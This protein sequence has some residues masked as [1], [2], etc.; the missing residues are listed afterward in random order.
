MNISDLQLKKINIYGKENIFLGTAQDGKKYFVKFYPEGREV[1]MK[2]EIAC[3]KELRISNMFKC[4]GGDFK[5]KYIILEY[6]SRL[7]DLKPAKKDIDELFDIIFNVFASIDPS[8]LPEVKYSKIANVVNIVMRRIE[9][10]QKKQIIGEQGNMLE[11]FE[12]AREII[13]NGNV[14]VHADFIFQNLKR[15]KGNI[16]IIDFEYARLGHCLMDAAALYMDLSLNPRVQKYFY[17]KLQKHSSFDEEL[18]RVLVWR[19]A[20]DQVY[21]LQNLKK[22]RSYQTSLKTLKNFKF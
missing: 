5:E 2:R 17:S 12:T 11:N 6:A 20:L 3:Y 4:F 13:K 18:F 16:F 22:A 8:F 1:D 10:L 15:Y 19:R 14:F 7:I 9:E 21:F